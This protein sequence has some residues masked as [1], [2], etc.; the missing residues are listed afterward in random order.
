MDGGLKWLRL[1]ARNA[2]EPQGKSGEGLA[3]TWRKND[4][5]FVQQMRELVVKTIPGIRL[6]C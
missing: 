6:K 2:A 1:S 5:S 4:V 3:T